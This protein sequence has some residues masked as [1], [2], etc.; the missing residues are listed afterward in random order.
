VWSGGRRVEAVENK[1]KS[2]KGPACSSIELIPPNGRD[3]E[4]M[5]FK[6]KAWVEA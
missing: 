2:P 5:V 4:S 6:K 1:E 3:F